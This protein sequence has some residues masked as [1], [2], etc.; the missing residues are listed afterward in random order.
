MFAIYGW[1]VLNWKSGTSEMV[2]KNELSEL[3]S[4]LGLGNLDL[5]FFDE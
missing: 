1:L 2:K 4:I 5:D 3:L